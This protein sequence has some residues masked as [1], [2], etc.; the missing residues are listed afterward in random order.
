MSDE[1]KKLFTA[2]NA[3]LVAEEV[4]DA[5]EDVN[6]EA[7]KKV[8]DYDFRWSQGQ[9][10]SPEVNTTFKFDTE[11]GT[12]LNKMMIL[13]CDP[14]SEPT[15]E[16]IETFDDFRNK[17]KYYLENDYKD[18][19]L[20]KIR[21]QVLKLPANVVPLENMQV[22]EFEI[23]D[24]PDVDYTLVV[25]KNASQSFTPG[26]FAK[27]ITE[28]AMDT[29][30]E[31]MEIVNRKR[32]EN[33]GMDNPDNMWAYIENAYK[34]KYLYEVQLDLFVDYSLAKGG[35]PVTPVYS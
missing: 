28:I 11:K 20:G 6:D 31:P 12:L 30:E 3:K 26:L 5:F 25:E 35:P 21:D 17:V 9:F 16:N 19:F 10:I 8:V 33:G 23:T 14:D 22:K 7:G 15:V 34:R 18:L 1:F 2:E 13:L 4:L 32:E 27:E 24:T 29:G